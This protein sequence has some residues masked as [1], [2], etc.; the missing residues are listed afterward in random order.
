MDERGTERIIRRQDGQS[1][2]VFA[3]LVGVVVYVGNGKTFAP[4]VS[5]DGFFGAAPH[6][7]GTKNQNP[8]SVFAHVAVGQTV[9]DVPNRNPHAHAQGQESQAG[10]GQGAIGKA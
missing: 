1:V 10:G 7:T 5:I 2:D 9:E 6:A 8:N 3:H 4:N